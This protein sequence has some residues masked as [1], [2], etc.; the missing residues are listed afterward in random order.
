MKKMMAFFLSAAMALTVMSPLATVAYAA[1]EQPQEQVVATPEQAAGESAAVQAMVAL[2][3]QFPQADAVA[4]LTDEEFEVLME[5]YVAAQ[6]ALDELS[7]EDLETLMTN[8]EDLYTA[9]MEEL[10][11]AMAERQESGVA[12]MSLRPMQEYTGLKLTLEGYTREQY[13]D[14]PVDELMA[15]TLTDGNDNDFHIA[16]GDA[17]KVWFLFGSYNGQR[18]ELHSLGSGEKVNLWTY[19]RNPDGIS[20]EDGGL[21]TSQNMILVVGKGNQMDDAGNTRYVIN[22]SMYTSEK[23]TRID[24]SVYLKGENG[25]YLSDVGYSRKQL[26]DFQGMGIPGVEITCILERS[27]YSSYLVEQD[28][29]T[30]EQLIRAGYPVKVF[31]AQDYKQNGLSAH[32]M[33]LA[34]CKRMPVTGDS[35]S[36]VVVI[37]NQENSVVGSY[38]VTVRLQQ[39]SPAKATVT[40]LQDG[41]M[42]PESNYPQSVGTRYG[43]LCFSL[44]YNNQS[45]ICR[46]LR[47]EP[48]NPFYITGTEGEQKDYYLTFAENENILAVYEEIFFSQS[49]AES[50]G[51]NITSQVMPAQE[52]QVPTGY[53]LS[54]TKENPVQSFT[55]VLRDGTSFIVNASYSISSNSPYD[56]T[57]WYIYDLTNEER[58]QWYHFKLLT[59]VSDGTVLDTYY[60]GQYTDIDGYQLYVLDQTMTEAQLKGMVLSFNLWDSGAK[61]YLIG[62]SGEMISGQTSLQNANW[63]DLDGDGT[64]D[65]VQIKVVSSQNNTKNYM[66]SFLPKKDAG[67]LFVAGPSER[68]VNLGIENDYQHDILV[69]NMGEDPLTISSVELKDPRNVALDEYWTINA[70]SE[71]PGFTEL[72]SVYHYVDENGQEQVKQ[73]SYGTLAN[74]AKVRLIP[75]GAGAVSGTLVI[76]AANGEKREIKLTGTAALPGF[77]TDQ[78]PEGVKY[79]PYSFMVATD[80]MYK[81]NKTTFSLESGTL[82]KGMELKTTGELYGTPQETGTFTFKIKV[83]HSSSRFADYPN[84]QEFT[85][86]INE[87]TDANV[88]MAS[89]ENYAVKQPLGVEKT[90]GKHDYYLADATAAQTFSSEADYYVNNSRRKSFQSLWLN[91]EK[92]VEGVDYTAKQGSTVITINSQTFANKAK[93]SGTNTI[94]MEF[95]VNG[96][97]T[98]DLKRTAQNFY[99]AANATKPSGGNSGNGGSQGSTGNSGSQSS[100]G[101]NQGSAAG[102]QTGATVGTG[103]ILGSLQIYVVDAN[104]KGLAGMTVELHSTPRTAVTNASG[105]VSFD[106][107]EVGDHTLTIKNSEGKVLVSSPL[108]ISSNAG[109]TIAVT[110]SVDNGAVASGLPGTIYKAAGGRIPQ[111]SDNFGLTMWV[112]LLG[113]SAAGL[114]VVFLR[115]KRGQGK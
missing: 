21:D 114:L 39:G 77:T 16:L 106:A 78:I 17:T 65:T 113:L 19:Y 26:E 5:N 62:D 23:P 93:L 66:V 10:A 89:D 50:Y 99:L 4:D 27:R 87:N 60:G 54:V 98:G 63:K 2:F 13:K 30:E 86:V 48:W 74:V 73:N 36:W 96:D 7:D 47:S 41:G 101:S 58:T 51:K 18:E 14:F 24:K 95:R 107:V 76:T 81:W 45:N 61:A 33:D 84:V 53:K 32:A 109:G 38:G 103:D 44:D 6:D 9:V 52:E 57:Y 15:C 56:S 83:T 64:V 104:N 97:E 111:T 85:L 49:D 110:I 1:E 31:E 43:N 79:V 88:F 28:F 115:K 20:Y 102:S 105:M 90:P 68:L 91:G 70:G 11:Q 55:I 108:T 46:S 12:D 25:A 34:D 37:L 42:Q 72:S 67:S 82:P 71:I 75:L 92:L 3:E 59:T 40:T 112:A 80:N 22:L 69:A 35:V 8:H 100:N 94:A 29:S